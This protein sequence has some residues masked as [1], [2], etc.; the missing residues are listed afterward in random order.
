MRDLGGDAD[1][2]GGP[3]PVMARRSTSRPP[4]RSTVPSG[5][6]ALV[7]AWR[8]DAAP[9]LSGDAHG[10][11]VVRDYLVARVLRR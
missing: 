11:V 6:N 5:R 1:V 8:A 3:W 2:A 10:E 9:F 4:W 7:D